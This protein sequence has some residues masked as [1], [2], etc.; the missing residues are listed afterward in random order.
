MVVVRIKLLRK[1]R[2]VVFKQ[3]RSDIALPLQSKQ[4]ATAPI[5]VLNFYEE[6]LV[7]MNYVFKLCLK[8]VLSYNLSLL[9]MTHKLFGKLIVSVFIT[10]LYSVIH[11]HIYQ[12]PFLAKYHI[13]PISKVLTIINNL[14]LIWL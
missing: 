12:N 1:E 2:E 4:D 10:N 3:T 9:C 13:H 8:F 5:R 11:L 6:T 14:L 7:E